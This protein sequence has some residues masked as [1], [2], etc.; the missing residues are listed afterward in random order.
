[1]ADTVFYT[2]MPLRVTEIMYNPAPAAEGSPFQRREFEYIELQNVSTDTLDLR[3]VLSPLYMLNAI[4]SVM[5]RKGE[6]LIGVNFR[7]R[8]PASDPQVSVNPLSALA[9]GFLRDMFRD[10]APSVGKSRTEPLPE[11]MTPPEPEPQQRGTRFR[12]RS[13]EDR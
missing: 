1:M 12:P 4:G 10:P 7:L 11:G 8:G 5:T 9:P 2:D 3:G 13:G 6:G